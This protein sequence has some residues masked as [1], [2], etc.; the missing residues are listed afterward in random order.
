MRINEIKNI[1]KAEVLFGETAME[2]S[3][4]A[5]GSADLLDDILYAAAK[6]CVLLTGAV[7]LDSIRKATVAEIGV[8]VM[9]RGKEIDKKILKLAKENNI[10]VLTTDFSLFV[11][12]GRLYSAGL[13]G[14]D[15]T[16]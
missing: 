3:I 11:A 7:T 12:S 15:G 10:P 4:V 16:W 6:D 9:V 13:R 8:I 14:L 1:L 5:G 2:N